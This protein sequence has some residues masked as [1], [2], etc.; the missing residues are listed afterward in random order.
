MELLLEQPKL[1]RTVVRSGQIPDKFSKSNTAEVP[2]M[3][4]TKCK[5]IKSQE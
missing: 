5:K 1:T 3:F 2:A 4:D